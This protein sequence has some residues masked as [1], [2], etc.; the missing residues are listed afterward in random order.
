MGSANATSNST[1]SRSVIHSKTSGI[2]IISPFKNA[3]FIQL[4]T[5]PPPVY[6]V[7]LQIQTIV[8]KPA[9]KVLVRLIRKEVSFAAPGQ[10]S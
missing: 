4:N 3:V 1:S 6:P 9:G 8:Q 10:S 2:R 7:G 5:V